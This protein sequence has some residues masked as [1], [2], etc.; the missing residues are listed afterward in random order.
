[1]SD[2]FAKVFADEL[3]R[4]PACPTRSATAEIASVLDAAIHHSG[5]KSSVCHR[6]QTARSASRPTIHP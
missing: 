3:G 6:G 5:V 4:A 2:R 1:M